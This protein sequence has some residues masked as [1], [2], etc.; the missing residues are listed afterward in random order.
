MTHAMKC[1]PRSLELT[2]YALLALAVIGALMALSMTVEIPGLTPLTCE[3]LGGD[4]E[5]FSGAEWMGP[6][7]YGD[8][9]LEKL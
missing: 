2:T 1:L 4:W 9:W 5:A 3:A 6:S 8:L 7:C